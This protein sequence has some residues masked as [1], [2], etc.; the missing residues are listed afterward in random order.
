MTTRDI[1]FADWASAVA[2][3][4]FAVSFAV[5]VIFL[6]GALCMPR[7]SVRKSAQLPLRQDTL[8]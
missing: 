1:I 8:L 6:I 2:A 7:R 3:A 4:A 5:F